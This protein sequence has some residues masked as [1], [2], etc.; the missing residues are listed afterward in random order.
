MMNGVTMNPAIHPAIPILTTMIFGT[1]LSGQTNNKLSVSENSQS[2]QM[3]FW[4]LRTFGEHRATDP[5]GQQ[6]YQIGSAFD[7]LL[8]AEVRDSDCNQHTTCPLSKFFEKYFPEY[9]V[10]LS[11]SLHYC[12]NTHSGSEEY[13][14]LVK[15]NLDFNISMIHYQD[16]DCLFIRRPYGLNLKM[17]HTDYNLLLFHSNPNNQKELVALSDVF[18]QFGN[19]RTFLMGD[20]N[21]GCH[22][23]SFDTLR[24]FEIGKEYDWLLSERSFTNVEQSCPY[25]R[26]VSTRDISGRLR[27]QRVLN[28]NNEAGRINSDHYPIAVEF[29]F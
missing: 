16:K 2:I 11:P 13:A 21:T 27:N 26:I 22:Y 15:R 5:I 14:M 8:F 1:L 18:H 25:D 29:A 4:N 10:F 6:L 19:Q 24:G 7:I 17:N 3:M 12:S 20:L 28:Q 23:V 9:Q